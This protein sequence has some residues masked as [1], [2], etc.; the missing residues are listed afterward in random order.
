MALNFDL[1]KPVEA[2]SLLDS[3]QRAMALSQLGMQNRQAA[4]QMMLQNQEDSDNAAFRAALTANTGADGKLNRDAALSQIGRTAP[5]KYLDAQE[6]FSKASKDSAD[7]ET[8]NA[9]AAHQVLSV[10]QP[11]VEKLNQMPVAQR[12]AAFPS[13]MAYLDSQGTPMHNVP[14]V[15]GQYV[16]DD[17]WFNKTYTTVNG[18]KEHLDNVLTGAKTGEAVASTREK[19]DQ[20]KKLEGELGQRNPQVLGKI[21]PSVDPATLIPKMVPKEHQTK[22]SD[23]IKAAQDTKALSPKI[24]D[25]FIMG[26]SKNPIV[27]AQG[28]RMFEGLINTTIKDAEGTVR[29]AAMDSVHKTMTPSGLTASPGENDTKWKTVEAYLA[30]KASAPMAKAYG[31]DLSK[32]DSTAPFKAAD[33]KDDDTGNDLIPNANAGSGRVTVTDGKKTYSILLSHLPDAMNDGFSP[34]KKKGAK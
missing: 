13:A 29:Q 15:N 34:V 27:A 21:D 2:P 8:A 30:S 11:V 18:L 7:S 3:Q 25:A 28:Q 5:S 23:E 31:I 19:N 33:K 12:A 9:T 26:T 24:Y 14:K 16:Y 4:R 22:V 17:D 10:A 1:L 6:R 20:A 32:H